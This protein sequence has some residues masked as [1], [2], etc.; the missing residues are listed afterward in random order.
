MSAPSPLPILPPPGVVATESKRAA[1]GRWILPCDKIRFV[2]RRPQKLGGHVLAAV[3]PTSGMPKALHAW[4]DLAANQYIAAGTYRKL[5]VYDTSM[6]QNDITPIRDSGTLGNNPF[7]TT[8]GSATVQVA[9]AAHG[10]VVGDTITFAGSTAVG[11]IT[12]NGTFIVS[13]VIDANNYTF[14]FTSN[15]TSSATG[16]GAAV[17][18]SYEINVGT[19][20]STFGLGWGVGGYGLGTYGTSRANSTIVFEA[21]IWSLDHFG[22][23]LLATYNGGTLY[24][25]DPSVAQPWP[26]A[27]IVTPAFDDMRAIVVTPERFV[28]ALRDGM[29]LS[30][31]TQGDYTVWTPATNNTAFTRT[32][33]EGARLVAGRVLGPFITLIWSDAALYIFQYTGNQFVYN[34]SL[35]ARNCGLIGPNAV[36]S[37]G[38]MAYWMGLDNFWMY[39]GSVLPM[40]N[41]EDIRKYVFDNL[42]P[43]A[44]FQTA[45]IYIPKHNDIMFTWTALGDTIPTLYVI[46]HINDQCWSPGTTDRVSG[47]NFFQGDSR[48]YMGAATGFIFQHE[49]T[50]N[51]NGAAMRC[52]LNLAPYAMNE[53]GFIVDVE[54]ILVDTKDQVGD[55]TCTVNGWDRLTDSVP[56]DTDMEIVPDTDAGLTDFRVSGRYLEMNL[57]SDVVNGYYRYGK[58]VAWIKQSGRRS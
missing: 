42:D 54:S 53:G 4:R 35:V 52:E 22:K 17:T 15:A 31:S 19:E 18:F 16:G 41:V 2:N 49:N 13:L 33:T 28:F 32:L 23:F 30:S 12:P 5:Y 36:V 11:G 1:E 26:R 34:S 47:T 7:T 57:V 58:P 37:A 14:V 45:A 9:D 24:D 21:R 46:Y 44:A 29:V 40:P 10:T 50:F 51:D 6:V 38:G 48:P 8:I 3:T 56:A 25:F 55:I 27:A 43:N 39:N 20:L